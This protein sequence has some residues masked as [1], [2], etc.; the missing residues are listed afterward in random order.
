MRSD[1]AGG[2]R[3]HG[4]WL[5]AAA[6]IGGNA[7]IVSAHQDWAAAPVP[8]WPVAI[9]LLLLLPAIYAW[10]NRREPRKA[11]LGAASLF[12]L[13]VL[14]GSLILP[15]ADKQLWVW[16]EQLRLVAIVGIVLVQLVLISLMLHEVHRART[17]ENLELA[18]NRALDRRFGTAGLSGLLKLEAR[19]WLYALVRKPIRVAFPG[20][21]H[22][23][24]GQQHGNASNQLAFLILMAAE[25]PLLHLLLHFMASPLAAVVVTVL[26]VYGWIFLLAEY[27]ASLHRPI[28]LLEGMDG[29]EA[30]LH[31]RYGLV[32]DLDLPL[33]AIQSVTRCSGPVRRARGRL[34]LVGMGAANL[35]LQLRP[36]TRLNGLF[37]AQRIDTLYLGV[38][39]PEQLLHALTARIPGVQGTG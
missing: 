5:L 13:G 14:A 26:S 9:D 17:G 36:G 18:I 27:R 1:T 4:F 15:P 23:Y 3:K 38:D 29:G 12:A 33:A 16:L 10:L 35:C 19:M 34:R 22:F 24:S 32:T 31:L 2:L 7:L 30:T 20:S 37:G 11:L 8:E 6:V 39:Q 25:I 21:L 28:S